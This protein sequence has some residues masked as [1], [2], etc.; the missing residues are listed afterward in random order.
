[1]TLIE[2]LKAALKKAGLSEAL[3][4]VITITDEAQI[5]TIIQQMTAGGTASTE[6]TPIEEVLASQAVTDYIKKHGFDKFAK[7]NVEV[8]REHDK[9][10]TKGITTFKKKLLGEKTAEEIAAEQAAAAAATGGKEAPEGMPA[11]F[12]PFA[13]TVNDLAMAKTT[14][15]NA[16]KAAAALEKANIPKSLK[17]TW[18]NRLDPDSETSLEEQVKALEAEYKTIHVGIVG[19]DTFQFQEGTEP[20]KTGELT[21]AAKAEIQA[22]AKLL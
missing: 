9:K 15:S 13:K 6:E 8:Q 20:A 2:K 21:A 18:S 12:A 17:T 7:L 16:E 3:G 10:V 5:E 22:N 19:K 11:W 14:Q 1:M 4:D